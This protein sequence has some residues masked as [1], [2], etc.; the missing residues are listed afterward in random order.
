MAAGQAALDRAVYAKN[1]R[2]AIEDR[3]RE[4]RFRE[5]K[6]G[7][8][9]LAEEAW[10]KAW[11]EACATCWLGQREIRPTTAVVR[12]TLEA[13]SELDSALEKRAEWTDRIAKMQRDQIQFRTEVD[14]LA[15]SIGLSPSSD[16]LAHCQAVVDCIAGTA[17][18]IGRRLEVE[19]RLGVEQDKARV[20]AD[21]T[22]EVQA[23]AS[24]MMS[25]F[26][27]GSLT[28]VDGRLRAV[29]RKADLEARSTKARDDLLEG[30]RAETVEQAESI[31]DTI[32]RGSREAEITICSSP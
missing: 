20:L 29:A 14:A 4:L 1:L 19:A 21:E 32:D 17:K 25:L 26:E 30:V 3:R 22:A 5:K 7:D 31:L 28:E 23:Q 27:V 8:A 10:S 24:Q 18:T 12:E 15:A 6:L 11:R 2:A 13:L 16:T 9:R